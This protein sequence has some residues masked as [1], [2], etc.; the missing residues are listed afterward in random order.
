MHIHTCK[1]IHRVVYIYVKILY[2]RTLIKILKI[3]GWEG[4]Q[5]SF[6]G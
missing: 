3:W 2:V 1:T 4:Q 6:G 5:Y